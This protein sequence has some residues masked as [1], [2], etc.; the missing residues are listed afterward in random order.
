MT[1]KIVIF[2]I[3]VI[4]INGTATA[5]SCHG[6]K[7]ISQ[8]YD[9]YDHIFL[10]KITAARLIESEKDEIVMGD[11]AGFNL[12]PEHLEIDISIVEIF[13]GDPS[14]VKKVVALTHGNSCAIEV[15]VGGEYLIYTNKSQVALISCSNNKIVTSL[16]PIEYIEKTRKEI[17]F[18]R[19]N[20]DKRISN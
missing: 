3:L 19:S 13:K 15:I 7:E 10:V 18:L 17:D 4:G 12:F 16:A 20:R 5:C 8:A 1:K 11:R 6:G 9:F 14:F 2:I